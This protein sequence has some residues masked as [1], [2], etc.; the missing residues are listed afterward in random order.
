MRIELSKVSTFF[1][2]LNDCILCDTH[3]GHCPGVIKKSGLTLY[4]KLYTGNRSRSCVLGVMSP[5]RYLCAMPVNVVP[6]YCTQF[7]YT[8]P[9]YSFQFFYTVY[10]G[11]GRRA[12][13][14]PPP[15]NK[16][17]SNFI[18]LYTITSRYSSQ[19][20]LL[21]RCNNETACSSNSSVL[22]PT[23]FGASGHCEWHPS[24]SAQ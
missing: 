5:A 11:G 6:D 16:S 17:I 3:R 20:T 18:T 10:G 12:P 14:C 19:L 13:R 15:H 8:G 21:P 22:A 1:S 2:V 24:P 4:H 9:F 23:P 7:I